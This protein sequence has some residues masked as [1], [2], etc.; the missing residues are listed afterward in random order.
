MK[1]PDRIIPDENNTI[2][3]DYKSDGL[4]TDNN[5][6]TAGMPHYYR[7]AERKLAKQQRKLKNKKTGSH[8]YIRQKIL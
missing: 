5:G 7:K 2:E 3:L 6:K 4:Y 1:E 8:N